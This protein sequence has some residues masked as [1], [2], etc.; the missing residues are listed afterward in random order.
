MFGR[1]ITAMATPFGSD[2]SLDLARAKD[3]ARHLVASGSD[4][5]VVCGST[6]ESPT[7]TFDEKRALL[8]A[9]VETVGGRADVIAG[10]GTYDT[11]ESIHLSKMA[12][13]A[14]ANGLLVVTPYYSRPPQSGLLAHFTAIA[15]AVDLPIILYDIPI[16]TGRKI[17]HPTLL[18]LAE[19]PNIV[20]VKDA[21]ADLAGTARLVAETPSDFTVWSGDDVLTLPMLAVGAYGVISVASHLVG[22]RIQ[23]MIAT[24]LKGDAEGAAAINREI[25]PV[26]DVLFITSN[27]I[28][29]KAALE[30]AGQ[31]AGDPRLPLV[32]ATDDERAHIRAVLQKLGL[33]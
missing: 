1:V 21:A 23:D 22:Q 20:G 25:L 13:E 17:E 19:V 18:K 9:V 26:I 15:E 3:L 32:P 29:L 30:M 4:G 12:R 28:P 11:A 2:G 27:P 24:H 5:L 33:V 8:E 6:G 31:P 16:R 10:T 7:L 14:G